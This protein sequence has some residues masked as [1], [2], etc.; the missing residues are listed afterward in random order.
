MTLLRTLA[1]RLLPMWLVGP[2]SSSLFLALAGTLHIYGCQQKHLDSNEVPLDPFFNLF[3]YYFLHLR[4]S[5]LPFWILDLRTISSHKNRHFWFRYHQLG[6]T[7]LACGQ[8]IISGRLLCN[9][10]LVCDKVIHYR[11]FIRTKW[12]SWMILGVTD[13]FLKVLSDIFSDESTICFVTVS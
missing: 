10:N 2:D 13:I 8:Y 3:I 9:S 12:S 11:F 6:S 4:S 1:E 7:W 5:R